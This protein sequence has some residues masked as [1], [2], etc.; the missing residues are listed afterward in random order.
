MDRIEEMHTDNDKYFKKLR[1]TY[2]AR[3]ADLEEE[4]AVRDEIIKRYDHSLIKGGN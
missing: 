2:D 1:K 3:V 4:I